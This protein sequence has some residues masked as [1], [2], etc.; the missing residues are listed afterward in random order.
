MPPR[1]AT[2]PS[3]AMRVWC[4]FRNELTFTGTLLG[5]AGVYFYTLYR[6]KSTAPG[7]LREMTPLPP[8]D[9]SDKS[10]R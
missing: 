9:A 4:R 5:V 2:P 8:S 1:V 10:E 7:D 3:T 6:M